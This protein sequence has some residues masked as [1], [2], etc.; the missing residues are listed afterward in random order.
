MGSMES[1]GSMGSMRSYEL[2]SV[3][4]RIFSD[5]LSVVEAEADFMSRSSRQSFP[6]VQKFNR[7]VKNSEPTMWTLG[8]LYSDCQVPKFSL[9]AAV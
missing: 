1:I 3:P 6:E 8:S 5:V 4:K 2:L 9:Q 7:K